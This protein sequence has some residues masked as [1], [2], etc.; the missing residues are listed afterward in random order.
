M[1]IFNLDD[2]WGGW[3]IGAFSP[4]L[5]H[6]DAFEICLKRFQA[7]ATEKAHYQRVSTEFTLVVEG[8]CRIGQNTVRRNEIVEIPPLE[9]CDFEAISDVTLIAVKV[10]SLPLD[11]YEVG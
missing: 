9:V 4:A 1:R 2:Y 6:T 3:F 8:I 11:K 10:P 5:F 7:G